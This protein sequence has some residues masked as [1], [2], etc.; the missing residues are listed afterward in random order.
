MD[1]LVVVIERKINH[2]A[3]L[4]VFQNIEDNNYV[5]Q[6]INEAA[7]ISASDKQLIEQ[8]GEPEVDFGGTFD[9][10]NGTAFVLPDLYIKVISGLPYKLVADPSALPWSAN[11]LTALALYRTTMQT[12]FAT[13]FSTLRNNADNY[14]NEYV[15][16]V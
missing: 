4:R 15:T 12:R 9:D 2:M 8:F 10:G 11:T 13:A 16:P 6:F 1:Y 5:M 14:T 3:K 7:D